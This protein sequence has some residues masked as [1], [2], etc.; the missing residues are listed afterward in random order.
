[1]YIV[2]SLGDRYQ[3]KNGQNRIGRGNDCDLQLD[4]GDVSR[5]HVMVRLD[6]GQVQIMDLG[7][8]NGTVVNEKQL[9]PYDYFPLNTGDLVRLGLNENA[10]E[11]R[12]E[13]APSAVAVSSAAATAVMNIQDFK[14]YTSQEL[15]ITKEMVGLAFEALATGDMERIKDYWDEKMVWII[16]GHSPL[17]GRH[18]GLDAFIDYMRRVADMTG[19]SMKSEPVASMTGDGYSAIVSRFIGY[20]A[21]FNE[22]NAT[23]PFTKL[24]VEVV[25]VLRWHD[26]KVIEGRSA[27]F[28]EGAN[29]YD[30]FWSSSEGPDS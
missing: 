17:A 21:G 29:E 24:D 23:K 7:S 19:H 5:H 15:P 1:M 30:Q 11:I 14:A 16:P 6:E 27:I 13:A 9:A 2:T 20:R 4:N 25:Q 8:T 12:L 22:S 28:G 10:P 26:G 3:L 18:E